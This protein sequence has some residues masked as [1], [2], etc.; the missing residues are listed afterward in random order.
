MACPIC[1]A[2]CRCRNAGPSGL[3]CSCH[4]HKPRGASAAWLPIVTA[5]F[6]E[7]PEDRVNEQLLLMCSHFAQYMCSKCAKCGNCCGCAG[8]QSKTGDHG[9][10]TLPPLRSTISR[11]SQERL[12]ELRRAQQE[13]YGRMVKPT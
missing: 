6:H 12:R 3:C 2:H 4:R 11:E 1:G 8:T 9:E 13:E 5:T 10:L 7:N